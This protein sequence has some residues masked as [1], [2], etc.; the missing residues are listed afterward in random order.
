MYNSITFNPE[1]IKRYDRTGP[2]YT[3]YPT[4]NQFNERVD[5]CDY[6]TWARQSNED[7]IPRSL[8]LYFHLPFCN[9]ICYYCACNKIVTKNTQRAVDY[10]TDLHHEIELQGELFDSDRVVEQ[11]HW[12]G[13]TPTFLTAEQM[14]QLMLKI[15]QHFKLRSDDGGEYSIEVD[16]RS[17]DSSTI[18]QLRSLGFNR[19]SVGVQDF[20]AE[21]QRAVNRI[22]SVALTQ[23]VIESA[24]RCEFK[25][26]NID[27]IYGLPLQT[28][29]RFA[30]TLDTL[31]KINP[32]RIALYNYAHLPHRFPPQRRINA[33]DL[34]KAEEKLSILQYSIERLTQAGYVYI[35]M[36]HF[37]RPDDELAVAQHKG[38]LHRNFQGYSA[39]SNCDS[40]A[41]G[42]SAI[43]NIGDHF[44]QNTTDINVYHEQLGKNKLPIYRG[45]E[46]QSTD[47]LRRDIIQQLICF[48]RLD[49]GN[50]EQRWSIDFNDYFGP[51]LKRL[52]PMQADGLLV[53]TNDEIRVLD[54]GRFLVRNICMVFDRFIDPQEKDSLFSRLV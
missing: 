37:A 12:G 33:A 11:L 51:E 28:V 16:P 18:K 21:V 15:G 9:T 24:R 10:L 22:Q 43:S 20:D 6:T 5:A 47:I 49:I 36:D 7:P 48:F 41:M 4:A 53:V 50:I 31:I 13:G 26:I 44:C 3:S 32:D 38:T 2:R 30:E 27:L 52:E 34:P 23:S 40:V 54:D 25:S 8:S 1:L 42:V 17:T 14:R 46:S 35:G 19:L 39:H 45:Y 29:S